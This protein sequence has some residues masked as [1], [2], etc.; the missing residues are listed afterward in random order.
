[1]PKFEA[2]KNNIPP[3][4]PSSTKQCNKSATVKFPVELLLILRTGSNL[5]VMRHLYV[6]HQVS[7]HAS[8]GVM[9]LV[10]VRTITAIGFVREIIFCLSHVLLELPSALTKGV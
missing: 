4:P 9:Y 8:L 10:P 3:S 6:T 1:M 5:A 2:N 7:A